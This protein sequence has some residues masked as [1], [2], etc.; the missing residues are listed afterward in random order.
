MKSIAHADAQERRMPDERLIRIAIGL[1]RTLDA[2]VAFRV[3]GLCN[4]YVLLAPLA[5][6]KVH[7]I[8]K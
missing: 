8:L 3:N 5:C 6:A 1:A 7:M 2:A 4:A